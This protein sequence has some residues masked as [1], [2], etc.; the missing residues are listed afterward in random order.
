MNFSS[1]NGGFK[2][3]KIWQ[4]IQLKG[5]KAFFGGVQI[6][7]LIIYLGPFGQQRK[8]ICLCWGLCELLQST[9]H[10]AVTRERTDLRE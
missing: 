8:T 1:T 9:L 4:N 3:K 5:L 6:W 2:I 7:L 10:F